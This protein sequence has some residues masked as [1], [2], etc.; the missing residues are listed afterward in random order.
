MQ[1]RPAHAATTATGRHMG[2]PL[3]TQPQARATHRAGRHGSMAV[4][5]HKEVYEGLARGCA[6][7]PSRVGRCLR[8]RACVRACAAPG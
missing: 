8:H 2:L 3:R 6:G 1:G 5:L 4:P 7:P